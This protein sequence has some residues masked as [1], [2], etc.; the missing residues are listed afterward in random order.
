[1]RAAEAG[2]PCDSE[3]VKAI[4]GAIAMLHEVQ[5]IQ[6]AIAYSVGSRTIENSH[7]IPDSNYL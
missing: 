7:E 5:I 1:M 2:N 4:T 6:E 3:M